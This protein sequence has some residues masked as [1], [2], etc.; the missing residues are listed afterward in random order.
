MSDNDIWLKSRWTVEQLD[1]KSIE[2]SIPYHQARFEGRG[3]LLAK[4]NPEGLLAVVL[5][6]VVQETMADKRPIDIP[7]G[8]AELEHIQPHPQQPNVAF[9]LFLP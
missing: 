1:R 5:R 4:E 2:V 6:L 8:Q 3:E 9:R 7:L